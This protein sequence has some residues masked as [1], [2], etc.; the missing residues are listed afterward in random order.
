MLLRDILSRQRTKRWSRPTFPLLKTDCGKNFHSISL[1]DGR[2]AVLSAAVKEF[3]R[4]LQLER[5]VKKAEGQPFK[6]ESWKPTRKEWCRWG[7]LKRSGRTSCPHC[8]ATS[9]PSAVRLLPCRPPQAFQFCWF[10]LSGES[11][12]LSLTII[13]SLAT[14]DPTVPKDLSAGSCFEVCSVHCL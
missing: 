8:T 2:F 10:Y 7:A 1:C 3:R 4:A 11:P 12:H 13:S 5:F 6:T 14:S 9:L